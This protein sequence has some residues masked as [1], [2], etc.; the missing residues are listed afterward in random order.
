M[1][2]LLPKN[3]HK[4][5]GKMCETLRR[6][7]LQQASV[8]ELANVKEHSHFLTFF[9]LLL[10]LLDCTPVKCC[11]LQTGSAFTCNKGLQLQSNKV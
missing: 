2:D 3:G 10:V 7:G 6:W 11:T 1:Y 9:P 4:K 8:G 5:N